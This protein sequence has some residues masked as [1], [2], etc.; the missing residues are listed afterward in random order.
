MT[1]EASPQTV[2][3]EGSASL[4][5]CLIARP[6]GGR[7]GDD[8]GVALVAVLAASALILA[9]GLSLATTTAVEVGIAANHRDAVQ[10]VHAADAALE[11]A[12][13]ELGTVPLWDAVLDGAVTSWF[14]D[15]AGAVVLPDGS[16]LDVAAETGLLRCGAPGPCGDADMDEQTAERPWGRNNPRWTVYASGR[17]A[18]LLR[19]DAPGSRAYLVVWVGDDPSEND[20]QPLR[21]GGP[22]ALVNAANPANPG[23]GA[24][25]LQV[26]AYGP[27]GARRT[28]EAVVERD[29]RL[30]P[31]TLRIR[32]WREIM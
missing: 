21:D 29:A 5:Q 6:P 17:L 12:I 19:E 18:R 14:R 4:G 9:L 28:L 10:T 26:R 13:A 31:E 22:P 7:L 30:P 25:W 16:R 11:F 1:G 8:R 24:L 27:A 23:R 15:G 32:A 2:Q 20:A 3:H